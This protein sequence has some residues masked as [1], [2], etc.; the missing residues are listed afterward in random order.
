MHG[1]TVKITVNI[2]TVVRM[3]PLSPVVLYSCETW[4]LIPQKNADGSTYCGTIYLIIAL[5]SV[6]VIPEILG[7]R[8]FP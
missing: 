2:V 8:F 1:T 3:L 5:L 6:R 7:K 4:S